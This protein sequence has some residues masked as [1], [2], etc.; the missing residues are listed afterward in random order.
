MKHVVNLYFSAIVTL[1][2][3]A[4]GCGS[5]D[6]SNEASGD[7]I[8]TQD[9]SLM[10]NYNTENDQNQIRTK[11]TNAGVDSSK[12]HGDTTRNTGRAGRSADSTRR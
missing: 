10:N 4:F 1:T 9:S 8:K 3:A 7:T 12:V 2:V 11:D 5:G 6:T